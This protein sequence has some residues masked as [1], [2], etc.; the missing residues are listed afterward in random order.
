[1]AN[2]PELATVDSIRLIELQ[3]YIHGNGSLAVFEK[4]NIPEFN[5]QRVFFIAAQKNAIRGNHAHKLCSQLL[6]SLSGDI[7]IYCDD[8]LSKIKHT[9]SSPKVGLMIPPGIWSKQV[10]NSPQN[11]LAV[12]C[13]Y[14]YNEDEYIREYSD[15]LIF[16]S[17]G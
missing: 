13:D 17:H 10:Y 3:N 7:E 15:F 5:L 6:I 14:P 9:L 16:K 1:M 8:S 2:N 11:H 12:L 4:D